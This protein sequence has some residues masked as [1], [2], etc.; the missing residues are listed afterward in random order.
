MKLWRK[1]AKNPIWLQESFTKG[2]A[3]V[4]LFLLANHKDG[5]ITIRGNIIT[6]KRGQVGW[7]EEKL[8]ERWKWSR[9]KINR[10]LRWLE[11]IQ[12]IIRQ[13]SHIISLITVKNYE[14]YQRNNTSNDTSDD[15]TDGHQ[16]IQQTDTN[17]N[18]KNGNNEKNDKDCEQSSPDPVN[19]IFNIFHDTINPTINYGNKTCRKATE[20]LIKEYGLETV[21]QV[22]ALACKCHGKPYMPVITTPYQLKEKWSA[23]EAAVQQ[24]GNKSKTI[25]SL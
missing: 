22:A 23:L 11:T 7:S 17:K 3:W 25:Q 18:V 24:Q 5:F 19:Q 15:T 16:T 14:T 13:K 1:I 21:K 4:D 12:Q 9:G 8:G 6:I 2:Q 20:I 10:Y